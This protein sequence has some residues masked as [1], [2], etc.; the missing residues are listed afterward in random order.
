MNPKS[1]QMAFAEPKTSE[2]SLLNRANLFESCLGSWGVPPQIAEELIKHHTKVNYD[3][4]KLIFSQ[5]SPADIVMWVV[6]GV[7]REVCPNPNGTQTLVRLATSGDILGLADKLNQRGEWVRRLEAWAAGR[8][9]IAM[10]T[11]DNIRNLLKS[12]P[13]DEMLAIAERISSAASEWV[14]YYATFLGLSFRERLEIVLAELGR[15]LGVP[16]SDGILIAFEPTHSDLAEMIG[17]SRPVIG[18]LTSEL[19]ADGAI[20]RRDRKYILV[21]GGSIEAR[22]NQNSRASSL[23]LS[24]RIPAP[25]SSARA[26]PLRPSH[27]WAR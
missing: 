15:K 12:M 1:A 27:K 22:L 18:R 21:R 14:E 19:I 9:V 3:D 5:G 7:V 2:I 13:P 16:D 24:L 8:C 4:G 17:S 26:I 11:R 20:T 25:A 23:D 10:V 6:K